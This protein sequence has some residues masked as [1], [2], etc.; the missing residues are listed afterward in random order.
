MRKKCLLAIIS[1]LLFVGISEAGNWILKEP[2][3]FSIANHRAVGLDGKI[4]V[5]GGEH[6]GP[7]L[8]TMEVY[9]PM[10]IP[11][12]QYCAS[13]STKRA[14]PGVESFNSEIYVFGGHAG[15]GEVLTSVVKYSPSVNSW[16]SLSPMPTQR[17]YMGIGV[18]NNKM[19]LI[20]GSDGW[21]NTPKTNNEVYDPSNNTWDSKMPLPYGIHLGASAA[22]NGKIYIIGGMTGPT[23]SFGSVRGTVLEYDPITNSWT[24]KVSMAKPRFGHSASVSNGRIYVLGGYDELQ[25]PLNDVEIYDPLGGPQC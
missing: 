11:N 17:A 2:I 13:M 3:Q 25:N 24:T 6:N 4:Y 7:H 8:D 19:Y 20:G 23:P 15:S 21:G 12:W 9:D 18:V 16:Y 5:V 10:V 22:V 14:A 1:L